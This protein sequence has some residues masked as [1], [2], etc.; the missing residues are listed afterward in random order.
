MPSK[1]HCPLCET[2][3]P[4][5]TC[6]AE[7]ANIC[8]KC[9]GEGREETISCAEVNHAQIEPHA[10]LADFDPLSGRLTVQSVSQ[11]GYYLHLML[12]RCLEMD[13]H[14]HPALHVEE[15]RYG[16]AILSHLPM[17]LVR[18]GALPGMTSSSPV[19]MTATLGR[20]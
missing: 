6:P 4:R 16:D 10:C 17:R 3:P 11:V 19:P 8:A 2:R 13:F 15:E 20:R 12:A 1:P 9:C 14:F 7:R 18:A 5:R